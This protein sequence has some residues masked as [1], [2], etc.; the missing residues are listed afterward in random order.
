MIFGNLHGLILR[1]GLSVVAALM[2]STAAMAQDSGDATDEIVLIAIDP[3]L[4]DGDAQNLPDPLPGEWGEDIATGE[5]DPNDDGGPDIVIDDGAFL[6]GDEDT[7]TVKDDTGYDETVFVDVIDETTADEGSDDGWVD[8]G[9]VDDGSGDGWVSVHI[10]DDGMV[11]FGGERDSCEGCRG[12]EVY[13]LPVEAYQMSAG[14]MLNDGPAE[15][16]AKP[17]KSSAGSTAMKAAAQ[18]LDLYPQQPWLCEW[19]MGSGQ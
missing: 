4:G 19:Q 15:I 1:T 10:D 11:W 6:P 3:G 18:C 14:G 16:A 13:G 7:G 9:W 12:D 8:E 17:R 2:L 5:P